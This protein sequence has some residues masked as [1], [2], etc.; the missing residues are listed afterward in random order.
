MRALAEPAVDQPQRV[1]DA[2]E[3]RHRLGIGWTDFGLVLRDEVEHV[4]GLSPAELMNC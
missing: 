3:P 4:P 1:T 2:R